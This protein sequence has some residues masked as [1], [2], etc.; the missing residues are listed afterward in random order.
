MYFKLKKN[1]N[2]IFPSFPHHTPHRAWLPTTILTNVQ[3]DCLRGP[4]QLYLENEGFIEAPNFK[5][6]NKLKL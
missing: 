1:I 2:K 3:R 4:A 5:L 6:R